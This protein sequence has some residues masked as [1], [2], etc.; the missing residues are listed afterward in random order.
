V[1][2][3]GHSSGIHL[4]AEEY[5]HNSA[6]FHEGHELLRLLQKCVLPSIRKAALRNT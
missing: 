5:T 3:R 2:A 6:V 1:L 4:I